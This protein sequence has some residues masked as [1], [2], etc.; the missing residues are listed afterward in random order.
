MRYES[1]GMDILIIED[2]RAMTNP[3]FEGLSF[4]TRRGSTWKSLGRAIRHGISRDR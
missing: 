3:E 2:H 4:T 1:V